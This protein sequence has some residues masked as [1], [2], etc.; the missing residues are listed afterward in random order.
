M[1]NEQLKGLETSDFL[2]EA[3]SFSM[4]AGLNRI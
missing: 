3:C 4:S 2:E 1:G